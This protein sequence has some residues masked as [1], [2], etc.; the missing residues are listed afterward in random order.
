MSSM[1][2]KLKKDISKNTKQCLVL[3]LGGSE[4]V[5]MVWGEELDTCA[6]CPSG[7][8]KSF[9]LFPDSSSTSDVS[10]HDN[11]GL[12]NDF[13]PGI[14]LHVKSQLLECMISIASSATALFSATTTATISPT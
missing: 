1:A 3:G 10:L 4:I 14:Y 5:W 2:L 12:Y 8:A 11:K 6:C 7:V 13:F 9:T